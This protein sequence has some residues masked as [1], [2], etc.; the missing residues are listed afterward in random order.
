MNPY[1]IVFAILIPAAC[2]L[3]WRQ[4]AKA[5]NN[6]AAMKQVRKS[7]CVWIFLLCAILFVARKI[8][9]ALLMLAVFAVVA[10]KLD[11]DR[12]A[13]GG[14]LDKNR[15]REAE[16]KRPGF[17]SAG[18]EEERYHAVL[19]TKPG[20]SLAEIKKAYHERVREYHPDRTS[21]LGKDL[22]ELAERRMKEINE[23][24]NY[25]EKKHK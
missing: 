17:F 24:Y 2:L 12:Q 7:G 8:P 23:A 19:G 4:Y 6:P 13:T 9:L 16:P 21:H 10:W 3:I 14:D 20:M 22:R 5:T 18:G 11:G 25:F 1:I 15:G